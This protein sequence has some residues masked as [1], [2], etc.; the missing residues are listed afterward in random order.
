MIKNKKNHML[1]V[2][3][4][5]RVKECVEFI[6]EGIFGKYSKMEILGLN[7]LKKGKI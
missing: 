3:Y 7:F 2:G 1:S 4:Q 6:S 5:N